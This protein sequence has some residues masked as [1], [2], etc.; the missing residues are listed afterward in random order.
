MVNVTFILSSYWYTVVDWKHQ[1]KK[2]NLSYS[3]FFYSII[4]YKIFYT[5]KF[6]KY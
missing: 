5:Q 1:K 3:W 2:K 4:L 6:S